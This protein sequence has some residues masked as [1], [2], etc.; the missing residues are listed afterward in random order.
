MFRVALAAAVVSLFAASIVFGEEAPAEKPATVTVVGTVSVVKDANGVITA[1][2]LTAKDMAYNV[3]LDKEGLKLA[4]FD[5]KE[6]KVQGTVETKDNENW[7]T[8]VASKEI[9]KAKKAA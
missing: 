8:V 6:V 5:G 1:V 2:K 4:D 7:I 3:V 9:P